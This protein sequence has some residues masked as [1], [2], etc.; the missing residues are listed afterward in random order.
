MEKTLHCSIDG[1]EL[2]S[3][4]LA[5][6]DETALSIL[7]PVSVTIDLK[8]PDSHRMSPLMFKK[9][10]PTPVYAQSLEVGI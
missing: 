10:S 9:P 6:E 8:P 2:F 7:D 1:L 5:N 4:S 3:C